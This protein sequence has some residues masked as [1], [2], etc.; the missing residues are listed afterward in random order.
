MK[1][2]QLSDPKLFCVQIVLKNEKHFK[3]PLKVYSF[4][5]NFAISDICTAVS[6][7]KLYK[8]LTLPEKNRK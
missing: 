3:N 2:Q 1:C 7:G 5:I 4:L 6:H 8:L